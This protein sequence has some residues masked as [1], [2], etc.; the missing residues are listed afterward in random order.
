MRSERNQKPQSIPPPPEP[1]LL[2]LRRGGRSKKGA[3]GGG[4]QQNSKALT[5]ARR[6]AC[7]P[8]ARVSLQGHSRPAHR[9]A[10]HAADVQLFSRA[11]LRQTFAGCS[12]P[13][14]PGLTCFSTVCTWHAPVVHGRHSPPGQL[15]PDGGFPRPSLAQCLGHRLTAF[16]Y[17]SLT[18]DKIA[19]PFLDK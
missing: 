4:V 2:L 9:A 3:W 16:I 6:A 1:R 15:P 17:I 12:D 7:K 8:L 18:Q 11:A 10:A 13:A 14:R 19:F 5:R